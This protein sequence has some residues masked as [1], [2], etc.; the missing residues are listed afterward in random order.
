MDE[1]SSPKKLKKLTMQ[2]IVSS[3]YCLN[4]INNNNLWLPKILFQ[5]LVEIGPSL[6]QMPKYDRRNCKFWFFSCS[7]ISREPIV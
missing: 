5:E 4:Q 1:L 7:K 3:H 2:K 6:V